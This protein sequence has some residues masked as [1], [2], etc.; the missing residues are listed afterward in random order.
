MKQTMLFLLLLLLSSTILYANDT[1]IKIDKLPIDTNEWTWSEAWGEYTQ[2]YPKFYKPQA[3]LHGY[4]SNDSD[5]PKNITGLKFNGVDIKELTTNENFKGEVIWYRV[6]PQVLAPKNTIEVLVR[7]RSIPVSDIKVT[8]VCDNGEEIELVFNKDSIEKSRFGMIDFPNKNTVSAYI[9]N[10]TANKLTIKKV[11]LDN[12]DVTKNSS[13]INKS[14]SKDVPC[15][16]E[17]S[18]NTPLAMSSYHVLKVVNSDGSKSISQF[19][20]R[21]NRF[22]L[23]IVPGGLSPAQYKKYFFNTLYFINS[24]Q[25]NLTDPEFEK[26]NFTVVGRATNE[27]S[28]NYAKSVPDKKM[29]HISID[30]PDA[31][32][33]AGLDYMD[34]SGINIMKSVNGFAKLQRELDPY[35]PTALMIDSTYAPLNWYN[36]GEVADEPYHDTYCPTIWH[37]Y[38]LKAAD[39]DS[40]VFSSAIAPRPAQFMIWATF[41]TG[42]VDKRAPT[43]EE[44]EISAH[45]AIGNGVKGLHY[46][47][48]WSSYPMEIEGGYYVGASKC[49][50]LWKSIGK[51]NAKL[52]RLSGLLDNA[53]PYEIAKSNNKKLHVASLMSG[54]DTFII[55]LINEQHKIN[56]NN[57]RTGMMPYLPAIKNTL[58]EIKLPSYMKLKKAYRVKWDSV[59]EIK[60]TNK[61][62]KYYYNLNDLLTAETLVLSSDNNIADRLTL[63]EDQLNDLKKSIEPKL[64]TDSAPIKD[65]IS[66]SEI[67]ILDNKLVFNLAENINLARS[68]KT[69][70]SLKARGNEWLGLFPDNGMPGQTTLEFKLVVKNSYTKALVKLRSETPNFSAVARNILSVSNDYSNWVIDDSFKLNWSGG[71]AENDY[72]K[73][74]LDNKENT[75]NIYVR[76]QM[77][78]P[79]IVSSDEATNIVKQLEIELK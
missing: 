8:A 78:D 25:T 33:P 30:E 34:R 68:I 45:Y 29:M 21:D 16:V 38:N 35:H 48:D 60:L 3:T 75:N 42:A 53:Y 10:L 17:I 2:F 1:K 43:P 7:L 56:V 47:M 77:K 63:L 66:N 46:F 28:A 31:H 70:G 15:Y 74:E 73:C 27:N 6:N 26:N 41:N 18:L 23:G 71:Q 32:E 79:G 58:V 24:E 55:T 39:Y 44:N 9:D 11:L 57:V 62:G 19:R 72:L 37:G 65:F 4:I 5:L 12:I 50:M 20:V 54:K 22:E 51:L 61:N 13:I 40:K 52:T 59:E 69:E 14:Y 76:I 49:N 36:Y 67:E 64:V